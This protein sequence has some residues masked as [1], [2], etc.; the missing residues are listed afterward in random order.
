MRVSVIVPHYDDLQGLNK[1]LSALAGQTFSAGQ[2]EI[3]VAD[4]ASPQGWVAVEK[5]VAKRARLVTVQ[6]KGAGPARN[7]GVAASTGEIL[8]FI[9]SDCLP[10]PEWIAQGVAALAHFDIVGG[11]V[12]VL[13]QDSKRM[14]A[15]EAFESVFAFNIEQYATRKG[16]VGSG[17]LFCKR[18]VFEAVGGFGT[19]VS[20][21]VDW[22]HRASAKNL[23][24]GYAPR[25]A[26]GHPARRS[27]IELRNKWSRIN[28][29]TYSLKLR[30]RYGRISWIMVCL[31]LPASALAHTPRVLGST[32]LTKRQKLSALGMLYKIRL[33]RMWDYCRLLLNG[34]RTS[35]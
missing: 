11:R 4:N 8:A 29:Q 22:C 3:I 16:F 17:N 30:R 20:E 32:K 13:V 14:T 15:A 9:D 27:W 33:W 31:M 34:A 24:I 10:G 1:C 6:Q 5:A 23:S 35:T 25:A 21:D 18:E 28:S 2:T 26:V 12:D 7:G 19:E